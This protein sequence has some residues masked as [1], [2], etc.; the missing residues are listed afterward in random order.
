MAKKRSA[1]TPQLFAVLGLGRFGS[2][3]AVTLARMGHEVLAVDVD[4]EK[5][6]AVANEVTHAA[7]ADTTDESAMRALGMR[8]VDVA[9]V[10]IGDLEASVLTT[11][12]LRSQGIKHIVAKAV[13]DAHGRVLDKVGADKVVYPE[14]DMGFRVAHNL[15]SGNFI[16]YLELAPGYSIVELI[17]PARF[18]GNSLRQL[19][20]RARFGISIIAI[21]RGENIE[22]GPGADAVIEEG[23]I[24]VVM[25]R[26]D[27]LES[28]ENGAR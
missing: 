23:D 3:V 1:R 16:D 11:L 5:V 20:L 14:R 6:Q 19:D 26:D 8:N 10:S 27:M 4:E 28:I 7:Q 15:V 2:S 22:I 24:L 18:S 13:S 12:V 9:V 21:R 17:A 25:G